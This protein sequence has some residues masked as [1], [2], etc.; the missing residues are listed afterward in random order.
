MNHVAGAPRTPSSLEGRG[1]SAPTIELRPGTPLREYVGAVVAA[2]AGSEGI[3][4][5]AEKASRPCSRFRRPAHSLGR[6]I[7]LPIDV[8]C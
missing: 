2:Q 7:T 1:A 3:E 4:D 6:R 5:V 8:V